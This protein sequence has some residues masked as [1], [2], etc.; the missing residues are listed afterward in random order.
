MK[1]LWLSR[2][3]RPDILVAVT[4]LAVKVTTWSINE[5]RMAARLVGY[6]SY[7][8]HYSSIWFIG[9]ASQSISFLVC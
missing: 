7:S 5:D 2:L 9:D 4:L 8:A 3:S 6:V 1:L